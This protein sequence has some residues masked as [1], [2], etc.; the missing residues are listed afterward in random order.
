MKGIKSNICIL[1]GKLRVDTVDNLVTFLL[2]EGI[3]LFLTPGTMTPDSFLPRPLPVLR[4]DVITTLWPAYLHAIG[5]RSHKILGILALEPN[6]VVTYTLWKIFFV[7]THLKLYF[8]P[9]IRVIEL[10]VAGRFFSY[11]TVF[12]MCWQWTVWHQTPQSLHSLIQV[13][14]VNLHQIF[15]LTSLKCSVSWLTPSGTPSPL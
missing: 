7:I 8:A 9:G 6:L 13:D 15:I 3:D 5:Q 11:C 1:P 4:I 12:S 10:I 14:K 2:F